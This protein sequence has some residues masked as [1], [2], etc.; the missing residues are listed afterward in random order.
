M[1]PEKNYMGPKPQLNF[2]LNI[3]VE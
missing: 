1:N 2:F 3:S